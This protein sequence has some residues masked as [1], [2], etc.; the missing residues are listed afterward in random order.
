[1]EHVAQ[2][3]YG[4]RACSSPMPR[5]GVTPAEPPPLPPPAYLTGAGH[6]GRLCSG[7]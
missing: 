6:A 4:R 1:M 7:R 2:G 3:T 5:A